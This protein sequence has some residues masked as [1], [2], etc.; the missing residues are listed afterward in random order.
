MRLGHIR[1]SSS[2][3]GAAVLFAKKKNGKLRMCVDYRGIN[4]KTIKNR[5]PLP[6]IDELV[7]MLGKARCFSSIDLK[8]GY[9]QIRLR[10][11][12]IPCT[13][14]ITP[15]GLFEYTVLPFGLCNA[16]SVF[17]NAVNQTVRPYIGKFCVVYLDDILVFSKT[18]TEHLHHLNLV[19]QKLKQDRWY[20][21]KDKLELFLKK[22][23]FLG[24]VVSDKGLHPDPDRVKALMDLPPPVGNI[25]LLRSFLGTVN[26]FRRFIYRAAEILQPLT[27]LTKKENLNK[28][29]GPEQYKC[30]EEVKK[31][32]A[33]PMVLAMPD[34][35]KPFDIWCDAS[36]T[37][38]GGILS[39]EGRPIAFFSRLFNK[40][41]SQYQTHNQELLAVVSCMKEWRCYTEGQQVTIL[42]DHCP[43]QY[44]QKQPKLDG[45][46]TRW[47][48]YL[49]GF[50]PKVTYIPGKTNPSD[51]LSRL[52][53]DAKEAERT[54]PSKVPALV[55]AM[56][57]F[58]KSSPGSQKKRVQPQQYRHGAHK[59]ARHLQ[60]ELASGKAGEGACVEEVPTGILSPDIV[61]Q[62]PNTWTTPQLPEVK[63]GK[64]I[65]DSILPEELR[66]CGGSAKPV[67]VSM[68]RVGAVKKVTIEG[69]G[70]FV[71][72]YQEDEL[73]DN[74]DRSKRLRLRYGLYLEKGIWYRDP[75]QGRGP[76]D[77][78]NPSTTMRDLKHQI[79]VPRPLVEIVLSYCHDSQWTCHPGTKRLQ[80]LVADKFWWPTWRDD[81]ARHVATCLSCQLNK[82]RSGKQPGMLEPLPTPTGPF[83]SWSMDFIVQ[84]PK[85]KRGFDATYVMVDRF[86]KLVHLAACKTES[87]TSDVIDL[88]KSNI[89]R[90]HGH[91]ITVVSDRDTK[92]TS[93]E[94]KEFV[95][96]EGIIH[97]MSSSF[98]PQTDGQTERMNRVVE[99]A[100]RHFV[101]PKYDDWDEYLHCV[102]FAINSLHNEATGFSPFQLMYGF[103]P[104][105]PFDRVLGL[106]P[107]QM[108]PAPPKRDSQSATMW[109]NR[110]KHQE[111][112]RRIAKAK[113]N[114]EAAK[115]RMVAQANKAREPLV[116]KEGD[117]VLLSTKYLNIPI[118][119]SKKFGPRY[120]GP[121]TVKKVIKS[122]YELDTPSHWKVHNVF[123]V[124]RLRR[125]DPNTR[126]VAPP[127]PIEVNGDEEYEVE[128]I[129]AHRSVRKGKKVMTQYQVKWLG[130][131]IEYNEWLDE[132]AFTSDGSYVNPVLE[133]YKNKLINATAASDKTVGRESG[134]KPVRSKPKRVSFDP[135]VKD[136]RPSK[137]QKRS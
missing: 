6:R 16:P 92:F 115:Q 7:D 20:V 103:N 19:F 3:W 18:P 57:S 106:R 13:A 137:R 121:F 108:L 122:A 132:D 33:S 73:F 21:N 110:E 61:S 82:P 77:K 2:P 49:E 74:S 128:A 24:Y 58:V 63:T 101:S 60:E 41:Q 31:I 22:V 102:E 113:R 88:F 36:K 98:H 124:S 99:E 86:L 85:T 94:W 109:T 91:P 89:L 42:S 112:L 126:V 70:D 123:H 53:A 78:V 93:G 107:G 134:S 8:S 35:D 100:L 62:L 97:D 133:T 43:L 87:T 39:Q 37:G 46:Q 119:G 69:L 28:P 48:Q 65:V 71:K 23:Y 45:M 127:A 96:T 52:F 129:V 27:D 32:L 136:P 34:Y 83:Q 12:E 54:D 11:D 111:T 40:A 125:Y 79:C 5:Y 29:W 1:E 47:V 105:S 95:A 76:T 15:W 68:V 17:Q 26:T 55:A 67:Q 81:A 44:Y 64:H 72:A 84:L 130:Y 50:S 90:P 14:F 104:A 116:F 9:N 30:F 51:V 75:A 25:E 117:K 114:L 4:S 10:E 80:H 59:R 131:G 118:P 120:V 135:N 66:S 38:M 56:A